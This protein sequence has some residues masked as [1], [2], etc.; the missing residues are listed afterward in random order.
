MIRVLVK[1]PDKKVVHPHGYCKSKSILQSQIFISLA[2]QYIF[3]FSLPVPCRILGLC[4]ASAIPSS[5]PAEATA[6]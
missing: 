6:P 1:D 3:I 4:T 5:F 2:F